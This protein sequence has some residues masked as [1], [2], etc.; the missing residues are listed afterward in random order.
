MNEQFT[1]TREIGIDAAHRVPDHKSKCFQL[2]GHRYTVQA[3]CV[4]ELHSEGEQKGMT[5]DFSFLKEIMIKHIHDPCDHG[6]IIYIHDAVLCNTLGIDPDM[7]TDALPSHLKIYWLNCVPT[8][9]NLAKHWFNSMSQDVVRASKGLADL[10][11]VTVHETP[12]CSATY[13]A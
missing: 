3:T 2:H 1:T 12:N 9:E 5:I 10:Q 8:A 6:T 7:P 13:P 11:K 4:G